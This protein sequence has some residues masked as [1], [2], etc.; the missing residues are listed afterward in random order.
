MRDRSVIDT[1]DKSGFKAWLSAAAAY[2]ERPAIVMAFL[3]FSA[4]LPLLLVFGQLS[5]WLAEVGV[6][7]T[8]IGMFSWVGLAYGWKFIWSPLVDRI[9]L[10]RITG[11]LGRRRSWMIIAQIGI[12]GGLIGMAFTDPVQDLGM[13]AVF[14]VMVAFFSA[15]Q[16]IAL[17]AYRIESAPQ[18][19]Q[20]VLAA[21]YQGGY[22]IAMLVAGAGTLYIAEFHDWTTAYVAMAGL[23]AVGLITALL[24]PED[25][26]LEQ[27]AKAARRAA[28]IG[29]VDT[30]SVLGKIIQ[31]VQETVIGPFLDFLKRYGH[32]APLI[33]AF[34]LVYRISDITLGIMAN[35]FYADIGFSKTDVADIAKTFGV[36]VTLVGAFVG[37]SLVVRYGVK[38]I[39]LAGAI[40]VVATN[41]LFAV[42]AE[43]GPERWMLI[44][45]I[46]GDNLAAGIAGSAFIAYLSGLTNVAYTATQYALFTSI[47]L[48]LGKFVGGFSGFVVDATNYTTFFLYAAALGL[49]AII[50]VIVLMKFD[51]KAAM[52]E[53][54]GANKA[55]EQQ[56]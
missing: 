30:R 45:T 40:L 18:E 15:T 3:G 6:S 37:G 13:M 50:L 28:A 47:M 8:S 42:L 43:M 32:L 21:M 27:V 11:W 22:R 26:A 39:L 17:D 38:P 48:T 12:A 2:I 52:L 10:Y 33:L 24:S 5:F 44:L 56:L 16:D 19:K 36:V 29:S 41:L 49:P 20:A 7:K 1:S 14:A 55:A 31:F 53:R 9:P 25:K 51:L 35:A 54:S 46:S 34:I 4:G 23:M